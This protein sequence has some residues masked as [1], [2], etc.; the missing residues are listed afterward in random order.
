ML[1]LP[2]R[3]ANHALRIFGIHVLKWP[4]RDLQLHE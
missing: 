2:T 4:N 3:C 1:C